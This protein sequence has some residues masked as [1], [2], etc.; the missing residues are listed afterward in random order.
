MNK[1]KFLEEVKGLLEDHGFQR[2]E[3]IEYIADRFYELLIVSNPF[4]LLE[5]HKSHDDYSKYHTWP[6]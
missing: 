3:R 2:K 1:E 6:C 4:V 5:A